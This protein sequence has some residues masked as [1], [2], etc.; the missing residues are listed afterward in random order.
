[1]EGAGGNSFKDAPLHRVHVDLSGIPRSSL[2][3]FE[4]SDG[5]ECEIIFESVA[6]VLIRADMNLSMDPKHWRVERPPQ[7]PSTCRTSVS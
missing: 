6:A 3:T 4:Q 2:G 5:E 7:F 1:M